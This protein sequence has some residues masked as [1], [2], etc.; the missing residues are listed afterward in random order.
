MKLGCTAALQSSAAFHAQLCLA[1]TMHSIM[2]VLFVA[3][4]LAIDFGRRLG[5]RLC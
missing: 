5:Y 3:E 4:V 2:P 1:S